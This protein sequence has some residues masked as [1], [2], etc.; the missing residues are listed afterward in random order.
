MSHSFSAG[1][2]SEKF[3]AEKIDAVYHNFPMEDISIFPSL[4]TMP[5]LKGLNITIPYKQKVIPFLN[6]I[7]DE[8]S[9]IGAV[10]C[11]HIAEG[12]T[13]GYNTD[14]IGFTDS[15]TPLLAPHH[16]RALILGTGGASL[17]VAYALTQL[18]IP[19]LKVS[20]VPSAGNTVSYEAITDELIATHTLIINTTPLG[21]FP[22]VD[23]FP[24]IPYHL[25]TGKHLLYDLVYNPAATRFLTFGKQYGASV[26]NGLEMLHLQAEAAWHIWQN[27]G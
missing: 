26:K 20:R 24:P 14:V 13:T 15:L 22:D 8:A 5:G 19:F 2:F 4:L 25:L 6:A 7:S 3:A 18:N 21:T 17:A 9:A 10:N 12:K 11:I 16:N 27:A 23:T 1:Y